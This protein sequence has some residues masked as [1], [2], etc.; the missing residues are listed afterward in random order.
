MTQGRLS[1]NT[2]I[3]QFYD[4]SRYSEHTLSRGTDPSDSGAARKPNW[5]LEKSYVPVKD[6]PAQAEL[7]KTLDHADNVLTEGPGSLRNLRANTTP[8]EGLLDAFEQVS[9]ET[10]GS[11]ASFKIVVEGRL[12]ELHAIVRE[13][14]FCIG[15]EAIINSLTLADARHVEVEIAYDPKRFRLRIR[16]DGRGIDPAILADGPPNHWGL[17]GMR[18]RAERMGARLEIWSRYETGTEIQLTVPGK[19]AYTGERRNSIWTWLRDRW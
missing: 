6:E 3:D 10:P 4:D 2:C 9:Q 15:R 18:E 5:S 1:L 17:R 8:F 16:D 12:L 11:K 13:E 14:A 7:E 19:T